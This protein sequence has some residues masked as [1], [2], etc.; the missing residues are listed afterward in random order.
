MYFAAAADFLGS[1][2]AAFLL[3]TFELFAREWDGDWVSVALELDEPDGPDENGLDGSWGLTGN[4]S[5]YLM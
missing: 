5:G 1:G 3:I 2:F 4:F